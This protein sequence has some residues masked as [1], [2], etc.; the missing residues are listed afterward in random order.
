MSKIKDRFLV[1]S[2]KTNTVHE[3]ILK[4]HY[5]KRM[6]SITYC[7][8]LKEKGIIKGVC[9]FGTPV[10]ISLRNIFLPYKLLELNRLISEDDLPKNTLS[11]FVSQCLKKIKG[12]AIVVSYADTSQNH[13]GYIYQACNFIYTGLSAKRK[14]YKVKGMDHLH[15]ASLMDQAKGIENRVDFLRKKYGNDFYT[16]ER[17]RKHRY[18]YAIG[19]KKDRKKMLS[20][21]P[22]QLEGYPK[23]KNCNYNIGSLS[24][25]QLD[26]FNES[27]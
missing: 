22:Y 23:L 10:A 7:F 25:T 8:V 3:W 1:E 24:S 11:F 6:P 19:S 21:M 27:A 14:D 17:P 13:S 20:K 9:T 5:A 4:R 12:P 2:V 18:F 15:S 26:I 16:E